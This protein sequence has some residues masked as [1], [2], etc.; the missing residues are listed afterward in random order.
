MKK[1]RQFSSEFKAKVGLESIKE[2]KTLSQLSGEFEVQSTQIG[3]WKKRI[4]EGSRELFE[5]KKDKEKTA[6]EGQLDE[7]YRVIGELQTEN[8]YYKKKL[9]ITRYRPD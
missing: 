1:R 8:S 4:L 2:R 5:D 7:L 3:E 6:L 9:G